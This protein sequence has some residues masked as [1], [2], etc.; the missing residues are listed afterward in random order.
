M[1]KS[2]FYSFVFVC[3][4]CFMS[5]SSDSSENKDFD[6]DQN[7]LRATKAEVSLI[8]Q[9]LL[10]EEKFSEL[11][12]IRDVELDLSEKEGFQ[13][14]YFV[15]DEDGETKIFAQSIENGFIEDFSSFQN[16][17][18]A[19]LIVGGGTQHVCTGCSVCRFK[20]DAN[21]TIEGCLKYGSCTCIH[22]IT[23]VQ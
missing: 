4:V 7:V 5:C 3:L 19:K 6:Q 21:G 22:T 15:A 14:L 16:T 10:N 17:N 13:Y 1:K 23:E 8:S 12:N 11:K 20:K 9:T 18:S 2:I